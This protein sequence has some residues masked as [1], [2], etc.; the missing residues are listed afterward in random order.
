[1]PKFL[2]QGSYTSQGTKGI[3]QAGGSQR[4]AAVEEAAKSLGGKLEVFYFAF[5]DCDALAIIDVPDN[6]SAAAV[7]LAAN[8]SGGIACKTTV[9]MTP[10]EMDQAAKKSLSYRPAQ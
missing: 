2:L 8:A 9:L 3:I 7:S 5:G 1:M 6:V 4:R 10:E